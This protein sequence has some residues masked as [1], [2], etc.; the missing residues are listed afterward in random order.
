MRARGAISE[1][2]RRRDKLCAKMCA[3]SDPHN[4]P[5][6]SPRYEPEILP[7]SSHHEMSDAYGGYSDGSYSHVHISVKRI[8]TFQL[9]AS[10]LFLFIVMAGLVF[11][12]AS[13]FVFVFGFVAFSIVLGMIVA[14]VRGFFG[15]KR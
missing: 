7:P 14:Y 3:M 5:I 12:F 8:S 13:A 4:S 1:S 2:L 10:L 11:L 6:E 15:G 9:I